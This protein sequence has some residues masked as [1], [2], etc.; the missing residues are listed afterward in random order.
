MRIRKRCATPIGQWT[1]RLGACG[2]SC[3]KRKR[4]GAG[5]PEVLR[6]S[7][8][9]GVAFRVVLLPLHDASTRQTATNCKAL[10][11]LS[12]TG[13]A[14]RK[15]TVWASCAPAINLAVCATT[16]EAIC[17]DS[18]HQGKLGRFHRAWF[19]V[20]AEREQ[21]TPT[22]GQSLSQGSQPRS[23]IQIECPLQ[24]GPPATNTRESLGVRAWVRERV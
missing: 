2:R 9:S 11:C 15:A 3:V 7:E 1:E 4:L 23:R 10:P 12:C 24:F 16:P 19:A 18:Q 21:T 17:N 8:S 20:R 22:I 5:R 14:G 13:T 6:R